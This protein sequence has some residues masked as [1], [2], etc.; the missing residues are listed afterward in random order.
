M[1]GDDTARI[2]AFTPQVCEL[3]HNWLLFSA[4]QQQA[5]LLE[6]LEALKVRGL[7]TLLRVRQTKGS[8]EVFPPR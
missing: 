4:E 1:T 6:L 5:K 3:V 8:I 7:L 2:R